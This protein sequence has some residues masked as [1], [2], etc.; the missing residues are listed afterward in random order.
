VLFNVFKDTKVSFVLLLIFVVVIYIGIFMLTSSN[1]AN[2]GNNGPASFSKNMMILVLEFLLWVFLIVVIY[3]NIVNH[4]T[5]NIDF[6]AKIENLFNTKIA[7]LSVN[8][9]GAEMTET[10]NQDVSGN[11]S[12]TQTQTQCSK[13]EDDGN[14]EVFHIAENKFTFEEAKEICSQYGA[15]LAS[16]DEIERAYNNGA[17]WCNYG[18]SEDQMGFFPTQKSVYN[19]LKTIPGHKNDC[20]RTGING[21]YFENPNI[22]LGVNCFGVKPTAKDTDKDYMHAINHSP[23]LD[24]EEMNKQNEKKNEFKNFIIAPFNKNKWN[25]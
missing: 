4:D 9:D 16:Y 19:E 5:S 12:E 10:T 23:A 20:G 25:A 14:K 22:K 11:E 21:G 7:E 24:E 13:D 6:Q 2:M 3:I 18:W 15:R 8:A 1:G 17:N